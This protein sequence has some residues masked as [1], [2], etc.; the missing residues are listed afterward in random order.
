MGGWGFLDF[1][2]CG[3]GRSDLVVDVVYR[4]VVLVLFDMGCLVC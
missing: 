1:G 4:G 2:F 3:V